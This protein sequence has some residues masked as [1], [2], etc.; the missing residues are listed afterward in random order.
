[1]NRSAVVALVVFG[2][3]LLAA[4]GV[5]LYR[6]RANDH[7]GAPHGDAGAPAFEPP[8]AVEVVEAREVT[9]QPT[10]DL[11]GTVIAIR[12]VTVRN[13]LPGV[14]NAV[15]F[16]SGAVVEAGQTL[17]A[18]DDSTD[19]ADLAAAAAN[20]RVSEAQV[21]SADSRIE[22]AQL[23][24]QRLKAAVAGRAVVELELDRAQTELATA[25]SE[26]E[27]WAAE[28]DQARARAAQVETRIAKMVIKAPFRARAGLRSVHEGQ[29]LEE[30][31]TVVML[32]ELTDSVYLDFAI[33][34]EYAPRVVAGTVVMATGELLGRV[35]VPIEV[36]AS[37][38]M[39][40]FDTRNLRV[41]GVVANPGGV[42]VPGMSVQVR[43]PIEIPQQH[44]VVPSTAVRRA[45]YGSSVFVVAPD[46]YGTTRAK[47]RFVTL[48][49]TL[50]QDVIVLDGLK[51]GERIAAA[52]SFKLRDGAL[53]MVGPPPGAPAG[54][55]AG[56]G[57]PQAGG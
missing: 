52:G 19:R 18:L 54:P 40:N 23:E 44:V 5:A 41:R 42:L 57:G 6:V 22:L 27:R 26:R 30:G 46:E 13:E 17:L 14:V 1:M 25:Q 15:G 32:Q 16:D 51:A 45:A 38:A 53:V 24:V 33:P 36:V 9:W 8:T 2:A 39:V 4:G 34:Q 12:S 47:Q 55:G 56:N 35:P 10:A 29:Y 31:A 43:V 37:D 48:G 11:V 50:D 3:V 49:R 20:V 7:G 21:R 28:V